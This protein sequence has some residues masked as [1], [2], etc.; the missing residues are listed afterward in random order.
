MNETT[1]IHLENGTVNKVSKLP[2]PSI[3]Q[4]MKNFKTQTTHHA[5]I[6]KYKAIQWNIGQSTQSFDLDIQDHGNQKTVMQWN[7]CNVMQR[8]KM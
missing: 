1:P 6:L 5:I 7:V 2:Q 4:G 8:F 3:A